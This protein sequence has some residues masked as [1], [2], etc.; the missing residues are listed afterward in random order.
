M[1]VNRKVTVPVGRSPT[2]ALSLP[3][4]RATTASRLRRTSLQPLRNRTHRHETTQ[5]DTKKA[6]R[7]ASAEPDGTYRHGTTPGDTHV[8][9]HGVEQRP[10][11]APG[12]SAQRLDRLLDP[13][14]CD[15]V[16][17]L[18]VQLQSFGV[19]CAR[20]VR[21]PEATRMSASWTRVLPLSFG[22]SL[23]AIA[24]SACRAW[25]SASLS[26]P[27]DMRAAARAL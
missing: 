1:S 22:M 12:H 7:R 23:S 10:A 5:D 26:E 14:R 20:L 21:R 9:R 25:L 19:N 8:R 2:G 24:A 15:Q 16:L 6:S 11:L 27:C 17:L 13:L 3:Q 4:A 18:L